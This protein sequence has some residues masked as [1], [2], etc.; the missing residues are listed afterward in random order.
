[1]SGYTCSD[2][3]ILVRLTGPNVPERIERVVDALDMV[4]VRDDPLWEKFRV[5]TPG[6]TGRY[7]EELRPLWN[8]GLSQWTCDE[9]I[10]ICREHD[11]LAFPFHDYAALVAD[12][13]VQHLG[14]IQEFEG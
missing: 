14:V 1:D 6:G 12:P 7:T 9:A 8:R 5:D 13:Q 3:R 10:R 2:G 11:V 4:W